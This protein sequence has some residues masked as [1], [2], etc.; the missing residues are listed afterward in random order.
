MN[1]TLDLSIVIPARHEADNLELLLPEVRQVLSEL[2]ASYEILICDELADEHTRQVVQNN[3]VTLLQPE[4][5]GYGS[6]LQTGF[7][8][9]QGAYVISMDADLSH[10]AQ[11]LSSLWHSRTSADV[12]I[13][14]RYVKGGRAV[15]PAGR[16]LLSRILNSFFSWGLALPV[17][18]MSSGYRMYRAAFI[19]NRRCQ[20]RNFNALQELLVA[21][22]VEG[23]SIHEIP[24]TYQ[25]RVHGASHARIIRFGMNYL[26]TFYRLRKIRFAA[27]K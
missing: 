10:P 2:G 3:Q 12:I 23:Y 4:V 27:R 1:P 26:Q 21:A 15:M 9:A 19:K 25:P 8:H 13:A 22:V 16:F 11:F 18:D 24:F 5:H 17:H 20:S 6:A 14:S 7:A